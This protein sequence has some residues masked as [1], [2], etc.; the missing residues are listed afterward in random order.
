M[1]NLGAVFASEAVHLGCPLMDLLTL[2]VAA[3]QPEFR[4]LRASDNRIATGP[5]KHGL[6][7]LEEDI[8]GC[9]AGIAA[10]TGA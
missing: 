2:R 6:L 9:G 3:I 8:P 4:R 5:E 1:S 7:L 10:G